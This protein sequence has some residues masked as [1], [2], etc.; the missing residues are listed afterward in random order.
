MSETLSIDTVLSGYLEALDFTDCGPDSEIP[1]GTDFSPQA[2][3]KARSDCL[4][5]ID[6]CALLGLDQAWIIAGMDAA[7]CGRD[8]WF[9]R[10]RHGV[11]FWDRGLGDIGD[12]LTK[13]A[14]D[15]GEVYAYLG[16]DGL[17]YVGGGKQ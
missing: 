16:D 10:N 7:Q 17:V 14:H 11:G 5:F 8:F 6:A 9:T 2:L 13:L 4:K 1:S 12:K 15:F 3:D